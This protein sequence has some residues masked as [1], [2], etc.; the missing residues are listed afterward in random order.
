MALQGFR[1]SKQSFL[2]YLLFALIIVVFV[3]MFGLPSLN[4]MGGGD[5]QRIATVGSHEIDNDLMRSMILRHLGSNV[6]SRDD[7]D[8]I[9]REM[10]DKIAII[11]LL[12]DEAREAGLRVSEEEWEDYITNWEAQNP[13]VRYFSFTVKD[14]FSK[15]NFENGLSNIMMSARDYRNY[16]ENEILAR[17]YLDIMANSITVSDDILWSVFAQEENYADVEWM[18]ISEA[19]VFKTLKPSTDEEIAKYAADN[20]EML[21][22]WYSEHIAD[23]TTPER[24]QVQEIVIQRQFANIDNPGAKTQKNLSPSQR[25]EIAKK[26]ALAKDADFAAVFADYDESNNKLSNGVK[27]L[28]FVR[29]L[30]P[31]FQLALANAAVGEIVTA[32]RNTNDDFVIAKIM[33]R[34]ETIVKPFESVKLE[35]AKRLLDESRLAAR[36]ASISTGMTAAIKD[37]KT[38]EQAA[39]EVI[40]AGILKEAPKAPAPAPAPEQPTNADV[41]GVVADAAAAV[42]ADPAAAGAI[43]DAAAIVADAAA[44]AAQPAPAPVADPI[45]TDAIIISEADRISVRTNVKLKLNSRYQQQYNIHVYDSNQLF[46]DVTDNLIRGVIAAQDGTTIPDAFN[47]NNNLTFVRVV[48][49]DPATREKFERNTTFRADYL[50]KKRADLIGN[51]QDIINLAFDNNNSNTSP[52]RGIWLDQKLYDATES[53]KLDI[54]KKFFDAERNRIRKRQEQRNKSNEEES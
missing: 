21:N 11:F 4:K 19:D 6:Y 18:L 41:A 39:D 50:A 16:K 54:N 48:K 24:V 26:Q 3:F 27:Q 9:E 49:H 36:M 13:D 23:F 7:I 12:A 52:K 45:P 29:D 32:E 25:Y 2:I 31:D 42:V 40:Y 38:I 43:A 30:D 51:P 33:D 28:A 8:D 35:I 15:K 44:A 47:I 5:T 53:G 14:K 37:G 17:K 34:Q 46:I 1:D 22:N 20:S 10:T